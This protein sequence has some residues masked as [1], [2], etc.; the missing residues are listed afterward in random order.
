MSERTALLKCK[1]HQWRVCSINNT[2]NIYTEEP[3]EFIEKLAYDKLITALEKS[4]KLQS[5]YAY[6]L[7]MYDGGTR[8]QFE[9]SEKWIE[10]LKKTEGL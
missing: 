10:R 5:H 7:N 1:N 9:N 8:I 6:L 3:I 2:N 4:L